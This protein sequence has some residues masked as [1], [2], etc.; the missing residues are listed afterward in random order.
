MKGPCDVDGHSVVAAVAPVDKPSLKKT[1]LT[2]SYAL[3]SKTIW[4]GKGKHILAQVGKET[5][6]Y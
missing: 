6:V 3:Q 2:E 1:W 4:P 5:L